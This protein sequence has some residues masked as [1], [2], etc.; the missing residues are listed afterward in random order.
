MTFRSIKTIDPGG[1]A[2]R[3]GAEGEGIVVAITGTGIDGKHPHFARHANL[4]LPPQLQ[5]Y[6]LTLIGEGARNLR[7]RTW[8]DEKASDDAV[9]TA[10]SKLGEKLLN[11]EALIGRTGFTTHVAGVVAGHAEQ[12]DEGLEWEAHEPVM[13][14]IAPKCKLLILKVIDDKG[15]GNEFDTL[16]AL[17][18][19]RA[20]NARAG[21]TAI[22]I[23]LV[24][25][26]FRQDV[27]NY[28][29]GHTPV[30]EAVDRLVA[31]GVVVICAAGNYGYLRV[32]AKGADAE[33]VHLAS[34]TDPG[35]A[36]RAITVGA[37]HRSWPRLYGA[38][39]FSGRGPTL[40]GRM[41]PDLLAPGERILSAVPSSALLE[42]AKGKRKR[43]RRQSA[44]YGIQDGTSVAA[45]HVA[46]AAAV[47]L[48]ARPE[49]VGHPDEVKELLLSTATDLGRLR[50][51]QGHGL[52]NL[53]RAL[54]DTAELQMDGYS[55][56][57]RPPVPS[58]EPTRIVADAQPVA[59]AFEA[60]VKPYTLAVSFIGEQRDY[61]YSVVQAFREVTGLD[62][63]NI[64]YDKYHS[65][66]LSRPDLDLYLLEV[67]GGQSEL[68]VVF[69]GAGYE[70]KKWTCGLEWRV[71]RNLIM[72]K[73]AHAIMPVRLDD[74]PIKGLLGIDGYVAAFKREKPAYRADPE[75]IAD[76]IVKRLQANRKAGLT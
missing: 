69:L 29:C 64:F 38:S 62:R 18:V 54:G 50:E 39:Y 58:S 21:R 8:G 61:V 13:R 30:C 56:Q 3:H 68:V 6:D 53:S 43:V 19:V 57:Q 40:D 46:G 70:Q 51:F 17:E 72:E 27:Q 52:L 28:A 11:D 60:G 15:V 16:L 31:T 63:Q 25:L 24:P 36:E 55:A 9:L 42:D 10:L 48:S 73:Q 76:L 71:I 37:T 12:N 32:P 5:H 74:T 45:A 7:S 49:L 75:F 66:I 65:H 2:A 20:L 14:G 35:N 23:V 59:G 4:V 33:L 22:H 44:P 26:S 1:V 67:Y 47:I 41:K 34:I